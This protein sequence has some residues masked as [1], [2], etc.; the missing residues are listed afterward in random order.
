MS[1]IALQR[2]PG[3]EGLLIRNIV[4]FGILI[5]ELVGPTLTKISLMK[6]GEIQREDRKSSRMSNT[7]MTTR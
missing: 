5:Y 4:L 2:F 6:A 7:E 1:L 3:A